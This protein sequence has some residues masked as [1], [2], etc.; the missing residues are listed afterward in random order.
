M[1]TSLLDTNNVHGGAADVLL[2]LEDLLCQIEILRAAGDDPAAIADLWAQVD[3]LQ[4][5]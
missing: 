2:I 1:T 5:R 4:A 3:L